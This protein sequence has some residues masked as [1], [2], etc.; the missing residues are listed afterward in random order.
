MLPSLSMQWYALHTKSRAEK[1][2]EQRLAA[3][4]VEVFLPQVT[5]ASRRQDRKLMLRL[6]LFPGYLFVKSDLSPA[7]HLSILKVSGAVGLVGAAK[8]PVAVPDDTIE[9]L[10]ILVCSPE[11]VTGRRLEKGE[12]VRV[13]RGPL[14]GLTGVF[15][16]YKGA[17]RVVVEVEALGQFAAVQVSTD[18]LEP[19]G[20]RQNSL[21]F[22]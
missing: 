8:M 5:V 9:S 13:A 1:M 12:L 7:Q 19:L 3:S 2:V 16:R 17:D 21:T 11:V 22:Y 14:A 10:R 15:S 18:D 20:T 6:P 4:R